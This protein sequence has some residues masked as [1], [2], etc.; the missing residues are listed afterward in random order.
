MLMEHVLLEV[1]EELHR[2][3]RNRIYPSYQDQPSQ[4]DAVKRILNL[5]KDLGNNTSVPP[6]R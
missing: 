5:L 4:E 6:M 3:K 1:G 2:E